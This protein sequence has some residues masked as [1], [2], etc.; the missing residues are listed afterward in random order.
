MN[1]LIYL[2]YLIYNINDSIYLS[3]SA[4][5]PGRLYW[6]AAQAVSI[7][8]GIVLFEWVRRKMVVSVV[9]ET[10]KR[11][12]SRFADRRANHSA[13]KCRATKNF[14]LIVLHN[15]RVINIY[16]LDELYWV[17]DNRP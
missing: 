14:I 10:L 9:V 12:S 6:L 11:W 5:R 17:N 2:S 16:T 8:R 13:I 7:C 15:I 3:A 4:G 1:V